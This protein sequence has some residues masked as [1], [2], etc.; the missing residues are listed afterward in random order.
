MEQLFQTYFFMPLEKKALNHY[1]ILPYT[2]N[3]ILVTAAQITVLE[4]VVLL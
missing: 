3:T 4:K 1:N 2:A